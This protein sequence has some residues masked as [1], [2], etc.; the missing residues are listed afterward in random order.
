MASTGRGKFGVVMV[1]EQEEF[2]QVYGYMTFKRFHWQGL[3]AEDFKGAGSKG[4][5]GLR[6]DP[7]DPSSNETCRNTSGQ[8]ESNHWQF[9]RPQLLH[10]TVWLFASG[11][12]SGEVWE[13]VE[14]GIN[15]V[16]GVYL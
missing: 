8:L 13:D 16:Q 14:P 12:V 4:Q 3:L 1:T 15:L 9:L 6:R 5:F 2:E 7:V 11:P 10:K